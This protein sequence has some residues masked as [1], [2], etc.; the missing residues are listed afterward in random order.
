MGTPSKEIDNMIERLTDWRGPAITHLRDVINQSGSNLAEGWKWG[1]PV[2]T[3]KRNVLVLGAFRE[4]VKITFSKGSSLADPHGLFNAGLDSKEWRSIDF[5]GV[6][7]R[8]AVEKAFQWLFLPFRCS[9]C[10]RH[11]FVFR[12]VAPANGTA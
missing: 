4:H 9:L 5:R 8:N 1:T 7:V 12:W 3:G 10:G 11:F 6:G 2:W